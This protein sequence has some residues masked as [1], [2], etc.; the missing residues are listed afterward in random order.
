MLQKY[1]SGMIEGVI[2]S[3]SRFAYGSKSD[4]EYQC[5]YVIGEHKKSCKVYHP[6]LPIMLKHT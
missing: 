2:R 3:Q 1:R 5:M 6:L 4:G